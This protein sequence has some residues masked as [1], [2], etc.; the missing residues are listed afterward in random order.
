V[1][2]PL[3]VSRPCKEERSTQDHR[4]Q[5]RMKGA[6]PRSHKLLILKYEPWVKHFQAP[7]NG[8][9]SFLPGWWFTWALGW[10]A[11]DRVSIF[12]LSDPFTL[13]HVMG[14]R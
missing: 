1:S 8:L 9:S 4:S 13:T 2:E 7:R 12:N 14:S 11:C 5:Q 3:R 6:E 10:R